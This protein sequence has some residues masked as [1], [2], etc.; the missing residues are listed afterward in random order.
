MDKWQEQIAHQ[1]WLVKEA[2]K[3]RE[4]ERH[5]HEKRERLRAEDR[6][7]QAARKVY[8]MPGEERTTRNVREPINREA[9]RMLQK[10]S[11]WAKP[12][13]QKQQTKQQK[14]Q[15]MKGVLGETTSERSNE[16]FPSG[17]K[18][19]TGAVMGSASGI[20]RDSN[21]QEYFSITDVAVKVIDQ[22]NKEPQKLTALA[23]AAFDARNVL[24]ENMK[25]I[26]PLMENFN[27]TVKVAL[28]DVRQSRMAIIGEVAH[29]LQ[30]LREVRAF[31]LGKDYEFEIAR[32]K[33]FCDLCDRL[34]KL[35]KDG[36]LDAI[37]DT[38][39]KLA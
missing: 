31:L 36:T 5:E 2:E 28:E 29:L 1:Q 32:L 26:G 25:Q 4:K 39:I 16:N 11:E 10:A 7:R 8:G 33:E 24:D 3:K 13:A 6:Y 18:T 23:R 14:G 34:S 19:A 21:P 37:A 38:I 22:I 35:K 9:R 20:P 30:P 12:P 17:Q 27:A 15:Q